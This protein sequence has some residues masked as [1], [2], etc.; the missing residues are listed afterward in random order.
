MILDWGPD[1]HGRPGDRWHRSLLTS[2]FVRLEGDDV[3]E[4]AIFIDF[5]INALSL[6]LL[7][8]PL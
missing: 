3:T 2:E 6:P 8:L 5:V 1:Y 4:S 7:T